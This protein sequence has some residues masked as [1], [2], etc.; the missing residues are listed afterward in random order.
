MVMNGRSV[1]T[2]AWLCLT[3][4][5]ALA[6]EVGPV[7][8]YDSQIG[9][10]AGKG[11]V[12][13]RV[14]YRKYSLP[15]Q[16]MQPRRIDQCY[17]QHGY[18]VDQGMMNAVAGG[19][20][21]LLD[22]FVEN[23]YSQR[24][25]KELL[26][27]SCRTVILGIHEVIYTNL[28]ESTL[29]TESF[30]RDVVC[31]S[32]SC[33]VFGHS[34]GGNMVSHMARRCMQ[35]TSLMGEAACKDVKEF[36]SASGTSH[37]AGFAAVVYGIYLRNPDSFRLVMMEKLAQFFGIRLGFTAADQMDYIP[38]E[39]NP[40]WLDISPATPMENGIPAFVANEVALEHQG[41]L[42]GDYAASNTKFDYT[43]SIR[44]L[45]GCTRVAGA[46]NYQN[47]V[48]AGAILNLMHSPMDRRYFDA[49]LAAMKTQPQ[50]INPLTGDHA[51]LDHLTWEGFQVGDGLADYELSLRMCSHGGSAVQS[52]TT[53]SDSNHQA[54]A[55]G[56]DEIVR[57]VVNQFLH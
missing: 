51:Y 8:V 49:G 29:R 48:K 50:F 20:V 5:A 46:Q 6:L 11:V 26:A 10:Q 9:A 7:E 33:G 31:D 19:D 27:T 24:L 32:Q 55:G 45:Y 40:I 16:A 44:A 42:V 21:A 34:K 3:S 12:D 35:E 25:I 4:P 37:G 17:M 41:W 56:G 47:C 15:E 53:F 18:V 2:L 36:Y 28:Y 52:C 13:G 39:T 23:Y 54:T 57:D 1:V 14:L 38:G 30:M 22:A 43:K